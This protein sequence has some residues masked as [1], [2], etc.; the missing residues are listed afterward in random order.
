MEVAGSPRACGYFGLAPQPSML[1]CM[2]VKVFHWKSRVLMMG[3][4][5]PK[6]P[7]MSEQMLGCPDSPDPM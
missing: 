6:I 4:L 1:S 3:F 2:G 5:P 7:S